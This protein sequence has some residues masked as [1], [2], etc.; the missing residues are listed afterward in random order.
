MSDIFISYA[1]EDKEKAKIVAEVLEQQGWS[2]WWDR[3]IPPGKS[4]DEVIEENLEAAKVVLVLWSKTS[5][6]SNWVKEEA[7]EGVHRDILVPAMI[8]DVNIPLGFR[9]LQA[10]QLI[11]WKGQ[12][13][14]SGVDS[15]I[16]AVE[17]ILGILRKV[18]SETKQVE[19]KKEEKKTL[20][21]LRSNY[22]EMTVSQV[23]AV[24]YI[25]IREK[26]DWGVS[27]H[28]I[29][30]HEFDLET[31]NGEKVVIDHATGLMWHQSGSDGYMNHKE[32]KKWVKEFNKDE[33]A[34]YSDWRLPTVEEAASLLESKKLNGK[35]YI[36]S[37]FDSK[38]SWIWTGDS[39]GS[40]GAWGV[41]FGGGDVSW[42]GTDVD[43]GY[44][45]PV[46]SGK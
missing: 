17:N 41:G 46:R 32:A 37:V 20:V 39:Y 28:S 40:S 33:Y 31:I 8:D 30:E 13:L 9:R 15:L 29:I 2:V 4:F 19:S 35:L 21:H 44:V 23:Q 1:S 14:H 42:F 45:R 16:D 10:A 18:K 6:K 34:G 22:K 11:D 3:N 7:T 25:S 43:D 27:G 12:M 38:Q 36:D 5:V 26:A 24:P